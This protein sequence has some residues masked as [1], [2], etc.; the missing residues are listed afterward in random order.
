MK[1][2]RPT[3]DTENNYNLLEQL[4]EDYD[5][6]G[7]DVLYA[8]ANKFGLQL[9]THDNAYEITGVEVLNAIANKFGLQ[10]FTL[11]NTYELA[12][13]LGFEFDEEK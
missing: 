5:I 7:V 2:R 8:I 10:L 1:M 3:R 13:E 9:F 6:T 11:D 4:I 12:F